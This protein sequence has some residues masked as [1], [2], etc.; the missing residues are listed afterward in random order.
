MRRMDGR[1]TKT[2]RPI[3]NRTRSVFIHLGKILEAVAQATEPRLTHSI[4]PRLWAA[5]R[6]VV[7]SH[8][9]ARCGLCAIKYEHFGVKVSKLTIDDIQIPKLDSLPGP[10]MDT[11][12]PN[13]LQ[14]CT[15]EALGEV[16]GQEYVGKLRVCSVW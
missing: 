10:L 14:F 2:I 1:K 8:I 12:T 16:G 6:S 15:L 5:I 9:L 13:V 3:D 7:W 4:P 11:I